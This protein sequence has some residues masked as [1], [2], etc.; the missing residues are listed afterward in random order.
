MYS[1]AKYKGRGWYRE[2]YRH[3]LAARGIKTSFSDK[4]LVSAEEHEL[5]I[6]RTASSI[7]NYNK[8]LQDNAGMSDEDL[9]L[10]LKQKFG[11]INTSSYAKKLVTDFRKWQK[12]SI[13]MEITANK[14][15]KRVPL[16]PVEYHIHLDKAI[17]KDPDISDEVLQRGLIQS[18]SEVTPKY[19]EQLVER[20]RLDLRRKRGFA[21]K[22]TGVP[23]DN[24]RQGIPITVQN[25]VETVSKGRKYPVS[26]A[27]VKKKFGELPKESVD[28]ISEISFR[29]PCEVAGTKQKMAWAQYVRSKN[30]INIFSQPASEADN[31]KNQV[32]MV[33]YVVP[34]EA[35][36]HTA[37]KVLKEDKNPMIVE[38]AQADLIVKGK[39][40]LNPKNIQEA[41]KERKAMFG[42]KGTV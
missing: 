12:V 38:E 3:S 16:H 17:M 13:P 42:E 22:L 4:I 33:S 36:H 39:D 23:I 27:D 5:D 25:P 20:H 10:G 19:A 15:G 1:V 35:A 2:S 29:D 6:N 9:M 37:L 34:H 24:T 11:S 21:G 26:P 40:P 8:W 7:R 28:G 18:F 14:G 31:P 32:H 41:V 30:R